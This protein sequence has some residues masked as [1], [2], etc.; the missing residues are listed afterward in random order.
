MLERARQRG[1]PTGGGVIVATK[2]F[3]G[4]E[5]EQ[6]VA[7]FDAMLVRPDRKGERPRFGK[8]PGPPVDRVGHRH[9]RGRALAGAVRRAY[10]RRRL[11][12]SASACSPSPP[13]SARLAAWEAG[14]IDAARPA[15]SSPTTIEPWKRNQSTR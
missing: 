6:V 4:E 12:A 10:P 2:G 14:E 13:V 9:R 7:A 1:C 5:F 11:D 15:T 3:A 8:L